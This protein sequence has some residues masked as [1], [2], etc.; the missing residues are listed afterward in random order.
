M[1][2][3]R[4]EGLM[5]AGAGAKNLLAGNTDMEASGV[6]IQGATTLA[7]AMADLARLTQEE[8]NANVGAMILAMVKSET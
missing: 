5:E 7:K 1:A 4:I 8:H 6:A 3:Q 2:L